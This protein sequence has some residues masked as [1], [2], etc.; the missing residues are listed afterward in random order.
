MRSEMSERWSRRNVIATVAVGILSIAVALAVYFLQSGEKTIETEIVTTSG[1]T[2]EKLPTVSIS[3]IYISETAMDIPAVFEMAIE[4][5]GVSDLPARDLNVILDFGRAEVETCSYSPKKMVRTFVD[6]DKSYR[7]LKIEEIK[8]KERLYI[9]CLL[10]S[11]NFEKVVIEGGNLRSGISTDFSRYRASLE[12][13][14]VGF[15]GA[16][17]RAVAVLFI[18]LFCFKIIGILFPGRS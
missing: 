13:E 18:V 11:P 15:W 7:R 12:S 9:R 14:G 3:S 16:I 4:A 10:S 1:E 6:D 2:E 5:G 17:W 8:Q